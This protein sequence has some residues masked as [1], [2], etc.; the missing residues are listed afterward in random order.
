MHGQYRPV[1]TL[2]Q[3][4]QIRRQ[5]FRQHRHDAI[6]KISRVAAPPRLFVECRAKGH[7]GRNIGNRHNGLKPAW[8]ARIRIMG[9]PY[10]I[11]VIARIFRVDG[12]EGHLAQI[13]APVH[14][15]RFGA[16]CLR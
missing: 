6:G 9:G 16:L 5:T 13:R 14:A 1:F 4:A 8:I 7:I 10:R 3:R 15:K 12:N 2:D 11:I